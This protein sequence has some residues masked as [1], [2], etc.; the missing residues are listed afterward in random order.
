M[1]APKPRQV[2]KMSSS[3]KMSVNPNTYQLRGLCGVLRPTAYPLPPRKV[4]SRSL[5]TLWDYIQP[6]ITAANRNSH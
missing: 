1:A 3:N 4:M 2:I 6:T 5:P